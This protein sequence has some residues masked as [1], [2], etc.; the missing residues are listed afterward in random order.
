MLLL[1]FYGV[2]PFFIFFFKTECN[3]R[4]NINTDHNAGTCKF[5]IIIIIITNQWIISLFSLICHFFSTPGACAS[6]CGG[7]HVVTQR[8]C[9]RFPFLLFPCLFSLSRVSNELLRYHTTTRTPTNRIRTPTNT[10]TH[11]D[12]NRLRF[13][14]DV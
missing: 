8:G 1:V 13:S 14:Y 7:V 10:C 11:I 3:K 6:A 9:L 12:P 4:Q 2:S 5:I